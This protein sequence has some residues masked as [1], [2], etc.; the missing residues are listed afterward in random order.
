MFFI[1][2][3]EPNL[4]TLQ[5]KGYS[6]AGSKILRDETQDRREGGGGIGGPGLA[7]VLLDEEN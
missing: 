1:G 2:I 6:V 4:F 3:A 7:K 5:K